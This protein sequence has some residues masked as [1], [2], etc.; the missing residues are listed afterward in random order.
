M[1]S[2]PHILEAYNEHM[3]GVDFMDTMIAM[4][5]ISARTK[6]WIVRLLFH[7]IDFVLGYLRAEAA[8]R[9]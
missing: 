7:M 9:T 5:R 3:G 6:K 2:L 8:E 1:V 4:N